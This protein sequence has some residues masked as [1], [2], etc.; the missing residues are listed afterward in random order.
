[1]RLYLLNMDN[2]Q[3]VLFF[4]HISSS[5]IFLWAEAL[6]GPELYIIFSLVAC[7]AKCLTQPLSFIFLFSFLIIPQIFYKSLYPIYFY[8]LPNNLGQVSGKGAIMPSLQRRSLHIERGKD[9]VNS[10]FAASNP[11]ILTPNSVIQ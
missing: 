3:Y 5:S 7:Q 9:T 10:G 2:C 1:M 6:P 8:Y 4:S 11:V